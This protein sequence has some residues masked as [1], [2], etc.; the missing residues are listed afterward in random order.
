MQNLYFADYFFFFLLLLGKSQFRILFMNI[1]SN[2]CA[3]N[4]IHLS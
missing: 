3:A 1:W 2:D 4:K